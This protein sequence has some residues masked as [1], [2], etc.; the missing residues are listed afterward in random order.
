MINLQ[1]GRLPLSVVPERYDLTISVDPKQGRFSGSVAIH[2]EIR[3]SV[4]VIVLHAV[5]LD[6]LQASIIREGAGQAVSKI[7]VDPIAQ[8]LMLEFPRELPVGLST[9]GLSFTG[10]LNRQMKGLYEARVGEERYAFTQFEA[11]D[12]RRAFPCFDEPGL[13]AAFR[14]TAVVPQDLAVLSNMEVET[15]SKDPAERQKTVTFKETP[16][17]STYL[18]ALA[19]A[20]LTGEEERI[21]GTR[22]GIF[23]TPGN[24]ALIGFSQEV[25]R[26]C[27]PQ[28]ND[29]FGL[30]YPLAKLD[31]VGVPDFAMG[32]MENWGA[33]FFRENRLLVEP[34]KASAM[35]LRGVANVITHEVVHQWFGNLVTMWWWDDLWL[36]ESFATW[37]AC[38]IVDDWR[39]EW[40]SWV[41]FARDRQV[42]FAVD[43]LLST[44]PISSKVRTAAEAEEMFDALTYEK[45]AS[46]LR[47]MEQFLGERLFREG[48]RHYIAA[49][50]YGNADAAALWKALAE[51]SGQPVPEIADAWFTNPGFPMVTVTAADGD[52]RTIHVEQTRFLADPGAPAPDARPWVIPL[53]ISYE[54]ED[55]VHRQYVVMK[56]RHEEIRLPA[57]G[58]VRWICANGGELGYYRTR[59]DPALTAALRGSISS[60]AP[61]EAFGVLD[62]TWVLTQKG[63]VA[64][65]DFL[66]LAEKFRAHRIRIVVESLAGYLGTLNDR[67]LSEPD[68]PRFA[69]FAEELFRPLADALGWEGRANEGDEPKL[70]RAT[71]L[72]VMGSVCR[73][74]ALLSN[75]SVW[76][77]HYWNDPAS[78]DPTLVQAMLRLGARLGGPERFTRYVE[79][80]RAAMAPEERDRYLQAF[81]DFAD[82]RVTP[83]ILAL[84]L[85]DAVRGQDIWKPVR[86]LLANP[87][88]QAATWSFIKGHW[89][90]IREKGGTVGAQRIIAGTKHLWRDEWRSEVNDFFR[91][92]ANH[93]ESAERTLAQTLEFLSLGLVFRRVQQEPLSAWLRASIPL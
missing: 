80:Y 11:T 7:T 39:P 33:I 82:R 66:L 51:A 12:A 67:L 29:Y 4:S 89:A 10:P 23:T 57:A 56:K 90:A 3:Q 81:G 49:H 14:I 5:E 35:M 32:A 40:Q 31:L 69:Q 55:G 50:Q 93:I 52:F 47:M 28:L 72:W 20:K 17:M 59:Y 22:V 37:L 63:E 64:I 60:L 91:D 78:L 58:D 8:T 45:G 86:G 79:R 16:R 24:T 75:I 61:E 65:G 77:E 70:M 71:A 68:R 38:K 2:I 43:A 92:P 34:G 83:D 62:N 36:N 30:T 76:L 42:P 25:M 53:G 27:L 21:A 74:H 85:S 44:R 18:V 48:I 26:A 13:K 46:V 6:I 54:D 41:E 9:L 88:T 84:V 1:D 19:V 73:S 87:A 15:E